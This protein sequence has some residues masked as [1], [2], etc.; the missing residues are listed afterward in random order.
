MGQ[1]LVF[2]RQAAEIVTDH[3]IR[4]L[5]RLTTCPQADQHAGDDSA[6]GLNF[7]AGLAMAQKVAAAQN[8]FEKSEE[9][10][11]LPIII[12]PKMTPFIRVERDGV[13]RII[14]VSG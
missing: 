12:P 9:D 13:V 5:R 7:D 14:S 4:P 3:F 1:Q 2:A 6:V 8:L 10:F 11:N